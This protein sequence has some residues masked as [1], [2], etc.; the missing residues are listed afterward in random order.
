MLKEIGKHIFSS[1]ITEF[2]IEGETISDDDVERFTPE[3][4]QAL[5]KNYIRQRI[6]SPYYLYAPNA[7]AAAGLAR[8]QQ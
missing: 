7:K 8:E 4:I 3:M 5:Q 2:P 6:I 1:V